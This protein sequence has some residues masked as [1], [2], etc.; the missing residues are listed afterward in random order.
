[1]AA[2][3]RAEAP[4]GPWRLAVV[5]GSL[6]LGIF[7]FGLDTNIIGTAIPRITTD[8]QSLPDVSWYGS[9]YLLTVTAFQP[10]FGNLFKFFDAKIVYL[11]SLVI[12]EVGSVACAAA[13]RS[14]VL[15]FGRALLGFGAAGLLQ[16]ALAIIG[17]VVRLEKVPLFQG[18]VVSVLGISICV[19]PLFGGLLTQYARWRWCFWI[20]VPIGV[21]VIFVVLVFVP[22]RQSSNQA[23]RDLSLKEKLRHMDAVG[24]VLFIGTVC[25]LLLVLTWGGNTYPWS[26]PR[27][28]G[29]FVGFGLLSACFCYWIWRQKD[30][31]PIPLRVLLQ[32]SICMGAFTL[33]C[34]G[35]TSQIYAY[36][37]PIFFQSAQGVSTTT[38]GVRSLSK[39]GYYVPY[40]IAGVKIM[41]VGAGLLTLIDVST[42][43]AQWGSFL[44]IAGLGIGMAQQLPYTAIQATLEPED[45]PTGNAIAVFTFQLGGAL[46]LA[47]GQNL[48]ISKLQRTALRESNGDEFDESNDVEPEGVKIQGSGEEKMGTK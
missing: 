37:L 29:L 30:M 17:Y 35:M 21:C 34:I 31:A 16:G 10:L 28:I 46:G 18:T 7:L 4:L 20:N 25:C 36:Y 41:S 26:D 48:L 2:P 3:S 45:V 24:T 1:M 23:N 19:G 11:T 38:S 9:A 32:R 42:P 22:I 8:F 43:A 14:A 39:W 47:A 33:F 5:M 40:M 13:P 44:V 6:C 27:C 15:I 12:F